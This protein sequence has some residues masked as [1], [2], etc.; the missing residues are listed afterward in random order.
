MKKI[1][2]FV[3]VSLLLV[4]GMTNLSATCEEDK[5]NAEYIYYYIAP[6]IKDDK[7]NFIAEVGGLSDSMYV[8]IYNSLTDETNTYRYGDEIRV[9]DRI[10]YNLENVNKAF[11]Y[12]IKVYSS[13]CSSDEV[14]SSKE[15]EYDGVINKYMDNE[16]CLDSNTIYK[17]DLCNPYTDTSKM[18]EEEFVKKVKG[19]IKSYDRNGKV[20]DI[21]K[22]YYLFVLIPVVLITLFFIV[23]IFIVKRKRK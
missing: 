18:T 2:N 12:D 17:S 10:T 1:F 6:Y 22:K 9:D 11:N 16:V 23:R 20:W 14:L 5:E 15:F 4:I 3:F 19:Q 13:E 8:T 21:I 7:V